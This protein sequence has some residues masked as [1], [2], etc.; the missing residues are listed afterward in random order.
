MNLMVK[1]VP[2]KVHVV[3]CEPHVYTE[4]ISIVGLFRVISVF[5][6]GSTI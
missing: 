6:K 1:G 4:T 5:P 2:T 3:N